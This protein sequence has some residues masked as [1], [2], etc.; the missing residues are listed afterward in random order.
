VPA[1]ERLGHQA[2]LQRRVAAHGVAVQHD[3]ARQQPDAASL[4]E[5]EHAGGLQAE[6]HGS[7]APLVETIE[8]R[9]E[10]ELADDPHRGGGAEHE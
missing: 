9:P 5:Q 8:Q 4:P 7:H 10:P 2:R 6:A 3:V 1:A